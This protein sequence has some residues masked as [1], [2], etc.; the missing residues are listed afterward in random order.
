MFQARHI[1]PRERDLPAMLET[2]GVSSLEQL[3]RET[4]PAS[5]RLER[6]LD[7]PPGESEHQYLT[8]LRR[9]ASENRVLRS[10][11][12]LGYYDTI[13]PGRHPAQCDGEPRLVHPLH[14]LPGGDRAR[15]ARV[16]P[17]FPDD[18]ERSDRDGR[19]Q[20]VV[21]GR[22]HGCGRGDD[23]AASRAH[24]EIRRRRSWC[25]I[26]CIPRRLRYCSPAP[27]RSG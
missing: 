12:G 7:L 16:T 18:G 4:V 24:E 25:P 14:A 19:G 26:A 27:S 3:V 22:G 9:I 10:F 5:I 1:G 17:Q 21:A 2:I 8:R 20:R 11:I 6:P 15:P 23:A 13:T